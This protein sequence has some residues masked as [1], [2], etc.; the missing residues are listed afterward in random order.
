M[1]PKSKLQKQLV[2]AS[3]KLPKLTD[4]Q[5][6]WAYNNV[7]EHIGSRTKKGKITCSKCG[8]SWQGHGK[9]MNTL[10]GCDF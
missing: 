7:I 4:I 6:Q 1:K 10:L 5:I 8:H 9:L 2:E 3:E